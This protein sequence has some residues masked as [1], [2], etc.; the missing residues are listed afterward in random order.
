MGSPSTYF[1]IKEPF[2]QSRKW[3]GLSLILVLLTL[4][5]VLLSQAAAADSAGLS[6]QTGQSI[7]FT[8]AADQI[9]VNTLLQ[10]SGTLKL[11][12]GLTAT[13]AV[14][15]WG[16]GSRSAGVVNKSG[17]V[18]G[19]HL[20]LNSGSFTVK[21]TLQDQAG[22]LYAADN[23]PLTVYDNSG[24]NYEVKEP[25]TALPGQSSKSDLEYDNK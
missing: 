18:S 7:A 5:L 22:S 16:D 6:A 23:Q 17:Q 19:S 3:I 4:G 15:D 9:P 12:D 20:Y 25:Y 24:W 11:P 8:L 14:W 13:G 10:A 2:L 21:L 1:S